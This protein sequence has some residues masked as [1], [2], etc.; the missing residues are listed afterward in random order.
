MFEERQPELHVPESA[1]QRP[2]GAAVDGDGTVACIAC[3]TRIALA[4]ADIVGQGYRCQPCSRAAQL[5]ALQGKRDV[6]AHLDG[7]ERASLVAASN[8][9]FAVAAV[10][11]IAAI[12]VFALGG[13]RG[14]QIALA[15]GVAAVASAVLALQRRRAAT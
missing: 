4:S 10:T 8:R 5:A 12:A 13:S 14:P 15:M 2:A 9:L 11:A 7:D 1:L 6:A 3:A